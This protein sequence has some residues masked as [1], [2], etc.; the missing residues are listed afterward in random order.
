MAVRPRTAA[1]KP[2][3]SRVKPKPASKSIARVSVTLKARVWLDPRDGLIRIVVPG[4]F[5]STVSER[6]G[7]R[8]HKHL[9]SK[10][11]A[12]LKKRGKWFEIQ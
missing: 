6:P 1:S 8:L 5:I 10:L 9:Y 7:K 11:R 2:T 4:Q 3:P 12:V